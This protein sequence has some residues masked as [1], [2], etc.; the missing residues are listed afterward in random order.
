MKKP[1]ILSYFFLALLFAI[2]AIYQ[3]LVS[4]Q[5]LAHSPDSEV[6]YAIPFTLAEGTRMVA[7][8]TQ[9]ALDAGLRPG[10]AI[11]AIDGH[12]LRGAGALL[13]VH[14]P[15]L[16]VAISRAGGQQQ[17]IRLPARQLGVA[18]N[19]L[20]LRL[21]Q[22]VIRVAM[23]WLCLLLGAWAVAIRPRDPQAWLL[24]VFM[25][26]FSQVFGRNDDLGFWGLVYN[27]FFRSLFPVAIILFGY[28][29][30]GRFRLDAQA[31][32]IK[33]LL[34][35]PAAITGFSAYALSL[36]RW[37]DFLAVPALQR[38]LDTPAS[39]FFAAVFLSIGVF[40]IT[41][42]MKMG[43]SDNPDARR[44]LRML[45][46]GTQVAMAPMFVILIASFIL[47]RPNLDF[48][49]T[50]VLTFALVTLFLFPATIT[51]VIIVHR[52]LDVRVVI[53]Q[54]IQYTLAR[55][56]ARILLIAIGIGI[57][58]T[59]IHIIEDPMVR[60]PQ[61]YTA[62]GGGILAVTVLQR[63]RDRV[64]GWIDQRFFRQSYDT[65]RVLTGLAD[66]VRTIVD[67]TSLVRT[68]GRTISETLFVPRLAV[69]LPQNDVFRPAYTTG[70]D[71]APDVAFPMH[72]AT[73]AHIHDAPARVYFDDEASWLYRTPGVTEAERQQLRA[74][75]AQLILPLSVKEKLLGFISLG[76][77]RSEEPYSGL[78]LRLLRSLAAQTG[79]ALENG[80][81]AD[82]Y[83][84]EAAQR[85]MLNREVEIAREVQERLFPQ[86]APSIDGFD[87]DGA[88]R[89]ALGVGGDY[90]D[91]LSL[92]DSRAGVVIGDVAGKGIAAALLMA[93]LQASVRGQAML[94][95]HSLAELIGRVNTLIYEASTSS[96]YATLFYAE[97]DIALRRLH[98]VN[99]GHNPPMLLRSDGEIER[100]DKGGTV[101]G[102]LPRF[103]YQEGTVD[104]APGDVLVC[105]TDGIS[106]A[107]NPQQEEWGE[108]ALAAAARRAGPIPAGE[109]IRSL[110]IEA[111]RFANGAPQ[112]DDMTAVVLRCL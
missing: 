63:V 86:K 1:A 76:P 88:C 61:R 65:E 14:S 3:T 2:S 81:L 30:A 39:F 100:L 84:R 105:F 104:L 12:P 80:Q 49:P 90:Y 23:P 70:F 106:E 37:R 18:F 25:L 32:W 59:M 38:L 35:A 17:T 94:P 89:P 54:G 42:G 21:I 85:E 67:P 43:T 15:S 109:L 41:L 83:A 56:G 27:G 71:P 99:A 28:Y 87:L 53:R 95:G 92:P 102:L 60:R 101:V 64:A 107:E 40:F 24:L 72:A 110:M 58:W 16:T 75:D 78:D 62:V 74:L 5:V 48:V 26:C 11:D 46:I 82:A 73:V 68:V 96:R 36:I 79:L 47:R 112:H 6:R 45:L 10:D 77:K 108:E 66:E 57:L 44:R 97:L 31:P 52:A 111:D 33:W 4:W 69:L 55:G 51:Y 9:A 19:A 98:Y 20:E 91:F 34:L 93:T 50:W 22:I 13:D 29:F 103:P 8:L 7:T